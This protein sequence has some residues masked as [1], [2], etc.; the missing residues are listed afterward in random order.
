MRRLAKTSQ[1]LI[2]PD[3]PMNPSDNPQEHIAWYRRI[4][5]TANNR[6]WTLSEQL[7]RTDEENQEM[8]H[9]AHAAA[10]LWQQIGTPDHIALSNLLLGQ[11][12]AMLG[13]AAYA[14][15]YASQAHQFFT[16]RN[17]HAW[18]LALA[19]AVMA[20]AGYCNADEL[21]HLSNY[22]SAQEWAAQL[23]DPQDKEIVVATLRVVPI[24]PGERMKCAAA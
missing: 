2:R 15:R 23:T 10:H 13:Q 11:V 21:L 14:M 17:S 24:P 3:F 9:A 5:S 8:L 18:E 1:Q 19:H 12:H 20:H 7:V 6:A 4:A 16:S 22:Q